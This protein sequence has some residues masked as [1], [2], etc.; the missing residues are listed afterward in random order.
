MY[1]RDLLTAEIQKLAQA[2][3]RIIGLKQQ[4]LTEEAEEGIDQMLL[5][6]FGILFSD[7]ILVE[8]TDFTAFLTGKDYPAE[9]LDILSQLLYLRF[10]PAIVTVENK[11]VAE[12][13]QLIYQTLEIKHR[14]IN[15]INLD[16]Q[17]SA[18]QYLKINS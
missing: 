13:L 16:R 3:A 5:N 7:L 2:L 11:S 9:K 8:T 6:D 15:M 12:K 14:V 17:R 10:D 18:G 1:G 4:V